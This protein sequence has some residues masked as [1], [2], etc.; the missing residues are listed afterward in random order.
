MSGI[1]VVIVESGAA[2]FVAVEAGAPLAT[3]SLT[4]FGTPITLVEA[5]A[6]PL[7]VEGLPDPEE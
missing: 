4:G 1:P 3:V 2:P 6:P 5:N 7:V